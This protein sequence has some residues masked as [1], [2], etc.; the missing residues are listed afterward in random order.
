MSKKIDNK[1]NEEQVGM[2]RRELL[3]VSAKLAARAGAGTLEGLAGGGGVGER[4]WGWGEL[5][6]GAAE[7][8]WIVSLDLGLKPGVLEQLLKAL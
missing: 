8:A 6:A 7:G 4:G 1:D 2:Q 5:V 3:G